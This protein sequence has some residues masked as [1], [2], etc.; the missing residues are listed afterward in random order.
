[1][2]S[3]GPSCFV[4]KLEY[5]L[6]L[7]ADEKEALID[8]EK[9]QRV[10]VATEVAYREGDAATDFFVVKSGWACSLRYTG[11]GQR[12]IVQLRHPG[13]LCG[14]HDQILK[15][16]S[17]SLMALE[18]TVICPLPFTSL[19]TLMSTAP[20]VTLLINAL[21]ALDHV[22]LFD[23]MQAV[24]RSSASDRVLHLLLHLLHR[25]RINNPSM[26][27]TFRLPVTQ[28][29]MGDLLGLTNVTVSK[30]MSELEREKLVC[31]AQGTVTILDVDRA[32]ERI[33]FNDR[34]ASL[35]LDWL[36]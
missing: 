30:S 22:L 4:S 26:D 31:R 13:D 17:D 24:S 3:S 15:A 23:L 34:F 2:S 35:E 11:T 18:D 7:T 10:L 16:R 20:R 29:L 5:F 1:M 8:F 14:M 27:T 21:I 25:L 28:A 19:A 33:G 32:I 6:D 12:Q 9:N 36:R